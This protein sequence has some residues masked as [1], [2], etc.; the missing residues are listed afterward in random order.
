ME[1]PLGVLFGIIAML[2]W[3]T[4]DF[5]A[6]KAVRKGGVYKTLFWNQFIG[7]IVILPIFLA[8]EK[9]SLFSFSTL[10]ILLFSNIL[11]IIA[12][13]ALYKGLQIGKVSIVSPITACW[14][15]VVVL[16]SLVIFNESL[17]P[18]QIF[19]ISLAIGGVVLT[20]FKM[21]DI[22]KLK[23]EHT[24]NGVKYGIVALLGFG[25]SIFVVSILV[26]RLGW[27]YQLM[28]MR[29]VTVSLLFVHSRMSNTSLLFPKNVALFVVILGILEVI[30][31][32]S[33][34]IGVS[35]EFTS[36]VAPVAAAFPMVTVILARI[37][38]KELMEINQKIGVGSVIAGLILLS[39]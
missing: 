7:T 14:A 2:G 3:G 19:G 30:G 20:S 17:K 37:F 32:S 23:L 1:I 27:L 39:L 16:L 34:S 28:L 18:A 10:G 33:Y 26:A 24:I 36:I 15:I 5:F 29:L 22:I 38:L 35:F 31:F 11:G 8:F 9:V 4:A 13:F 21:R 12:Y 6:A 25:I